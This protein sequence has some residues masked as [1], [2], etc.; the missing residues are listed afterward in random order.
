MRTTLSSHPPHAQTRAQSGAAK[1]AASGR[2]FSP[3]PFKAASLRRT[4]LHLQIKAARVPDTPFPVRGLDSLLILKSGRLSLSPITFSTG[5]GKVSASLVLDAN[6]PE[7]LFSIM[8]HVRGARLATLGPGIARTADG[9]F[10]L[11]VDLAGAGASPRTAASRLQGRV[12]LRVSSGRLEPAKAAALGGD[13]IKAIGLSIAHKGGAQG[14]LD[15]AVADFTAASGKLHARDLDIVTDAGWAQGGGDIDLAGENLSLILQ[16]HAAHPRP[17]QVDAPVH[18][19]GP[20]T[21]PQVRVD[22][23]QGLDRLAASLPFG[24]RKISPP[25]CAMLL[26]SS[27]TFGAARR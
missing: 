23:V 6:R 8:G 24:R 5:P 7:P 22:P 17:L 3:T 2:L 1:P 20:L 11:D 9:D 14:R 27:A 19:G 10:D 16:G 26:S 4:D 12:A 25:T 13:L 15:C 18:I 21:H